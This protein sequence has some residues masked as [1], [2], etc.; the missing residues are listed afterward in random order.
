MVLISTQF[1]VPILNFRAQ[2]SKHEH[3]FCILEVL[4]CA[5][6]VWIAA[7]VLVSYVRI[8]RSVGISSCC[9]GYSEDVC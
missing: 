9:C 6:F 1:F 5:V 2:L 7:S 8:L 3:V 4:L